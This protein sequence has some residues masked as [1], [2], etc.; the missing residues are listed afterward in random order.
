MTPCRE[1][2]ILFGITCCFYLWHCKYPLDADNA[3]IRYVVTQL[4]DFTASHTRHFIIASILTV[5]HGTHA[6]LLVIKPI[7]SSASSTGG[8][9]SSY[10]SSNLHDFFGD[11]SRSFATFVTAPESYEPS[12]AN[13]RSDYSSY[14][15]PQNDYSILPS[16]ISSYHL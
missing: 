12:T 9:S 13:R 3:F 8:R 5:P 1:V 6:G 7:P 2:T 4:P 14:T 15:E 10:G 11:S 16:H